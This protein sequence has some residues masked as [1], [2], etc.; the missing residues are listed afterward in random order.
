MIELVVILVVIGIIAVSIVSRFLSPNSIDAVSARDALITTIRAAQ[1]AALGRS[2]VT[3]EI[4]Q[5]GGN[6][7]FTAKAGSTEVQSTT[8]RASNITLETGS[9]DA[10]AN[11]C[12]NDFDT[13]VASDFRLSFDSQGNLSS[14]LNNGV[15]ET[16]DLLFNGVRICVNESNDTAAC[17]S[18]AGYA[19]V[20]TCD[21]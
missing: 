3:F 17:V 5:S 20:G 10:S 8:I 19:Y 9:P 11:T 4:D 21:A 12:A 14:F 18:R 16:V 6:W 2:S 13:A 7:I 1:Q 15:T